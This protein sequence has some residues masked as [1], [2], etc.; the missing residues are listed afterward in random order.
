MAGCHAGLRAKSRA[1]EARSTMNPNRLCSVLLALASLGFVVALELAPI[2]GA[3]FWTHLRV[4]D[5]I[6]ETGRIPEH[7][8]VTYTEAK[9]ERFVAYE[10]LGALLWSYLYRIDGY[11]GMT[12]AKSAVAVALS[13]LLVLL[14]YQTSGRLNLSLALGCLAALGLNFRSLMRPESVAFVLAAVELNLLHAVVR[15]GLRPWWLCGVV[16]SAMA[17]T[18]IH[19]SFPLGLLF[20]PLFAVGEGL[21]AAVRRWSGHPSE[22]DLRRLRHSI[23]L[24]AL[25]F[26]ASVAATLVNPYGTEVFSHLLQFADR[27]AS[28]IDYVRMNIWEWQPALHP[29]F[30]H[31]PFLIVAA[32]TAALV[33]V[34]GVVGRRRLRG[35]PVVLVLAFFPLGMSAIRHIPWFEIAALYFLAHSLSGRALLEGWKPGL[36]LTTAILGAAILVTQ[37]GN[38][39]GQKPG[40]GDAAPLNRYA[41][42]WLR[43]HAVSGNVFHSYTYGDQL[44]Y[45]FYPKVRVAMD[46]RTYGEKYYL[47]YTRLEG[48]NPLV[49]A[50]PAEFARYL[51]RYDV[52][53]I[54]TKPRNM[55]VWDERG[56]VDV[57][58][59]LGFQI[60]YHDPG[61]VILTR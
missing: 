50:E 24:L 36:A 5:E 2:R 60:A 52:R 3:D 40:F 31:E 39:R 42:A 29:R 38:T 4:G 59:G 26:F 46:S 55:Y 41:I 10:W 35:A 57:L 14:A 9:D 17:W 18:N 56:H 22:P 28:G 44:A 58:I 8:E 23:G 30:R 7:F 61:T 47:E 33:C 53:T 51:E 20:A 15:R 19:P 1:A 21:D 37:V 6:R 16:V 13:A 34:S 49:L 45:Y 32:C 54:V 43:E 11:D 48:S 25:V 27:D 12:V